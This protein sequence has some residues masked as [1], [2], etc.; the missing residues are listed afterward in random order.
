M[1]LCSLTSGGKSFTSIVRNVSYFFFFFTEIFFLVDFEKRLFKQ[2]IL[3]NVV[4]W[5]ADE[6]TLDKLK[7]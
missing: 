1:T 6:A 5:E 4:R 3:G 2:R 7:V